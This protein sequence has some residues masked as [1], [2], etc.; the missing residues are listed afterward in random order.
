[1]KEQWGAREK[2]SELLPAKKTNL[3]P[4]HQKEEPTEGTV[5]LLTQKVEPLSSLRS[6]TK[7]CLLVFFF[8]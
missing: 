6:R 4:R 5:G 2:A 1:M 3:A 7:K 8:K